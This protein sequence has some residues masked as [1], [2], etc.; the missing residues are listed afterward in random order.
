MLEIG[1]IIDGKFRVLRRLG[2]RDDA[3]AEVE[4]VLYL[5]VELPAQGASGVA[6][7]R[8]RAPSAALQV[9]AREPTVRELAR[10]ISTPLRLPAE[11]SNTFEGELV[12]WDDTQRIETSFPCA[13]EF[14]DTTCEV[15]TQ[16]GTATARTRRPMRRFRSGLVAAAV[17]GLL[18]VF[19]ASAPRELRVGRC[20]PAL[21][22]R[23]AKLGVQDCVRP[24]LDARAPTNDLLADAVTSEPRSLESARGLSHKPR[25]VTRRKPRSA[26]EASFDDPTRFGFPSTLLK[27]DEF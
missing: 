12:E 11:L 24:A 17:C 16:A 9:L 10:A 1:D 8:Y 15:A 13:N 4:G 22:A 23:E 2:G 27:L 14:I 3:P 26:S 21:P 19:V 7:V 18:A 6:L 5:V 20:P 25:R